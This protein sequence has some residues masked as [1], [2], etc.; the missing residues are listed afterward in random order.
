[1][2]ISTLHH[3]IHSIMNIGKIKITESLRKNM[4]ILKE[5]WLNAESDG[6]LLRALLPL[7]V[8]T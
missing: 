4:V 3:T 1:M 2:L 5:T 7:S 6:T 8:T